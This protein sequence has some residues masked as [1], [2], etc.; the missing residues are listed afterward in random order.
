MSAISSIGGFGAMPSLGGIGALGSVGNSGG[1]SGIADCTTPGANPAINQ[2][3]EMFQGLSSAEIL[4]ALMLSGALGGKDK[5]N[6]SSSSEA[7]AFLAGAALASGIGR[8][9]QQALAGPNPVGMAEAGGS[10]G[11]ALNVMG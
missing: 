9:I 10:I 11:M 4:L 8:Q 6:Q 3:V 1:V 2:L 7:M 5:Q